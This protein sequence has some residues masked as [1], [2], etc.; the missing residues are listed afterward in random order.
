LHGGSSNK[1]YP[2][3]VEDLKLFVKVKNC[4]AA[5]PAKKYYSG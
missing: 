2:P 4:G 5:A 1:S 3:I